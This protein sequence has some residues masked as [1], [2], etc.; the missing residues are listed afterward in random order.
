MRGCYVS[1][2]VVMGVFREEP[3]ARGQRGERADE[4]APTGAAALRELGSRRAEERPR[5]Q[6]ARLSRRDPRWCVGG[7]ANGPSRAT[8]SRV[9]AFI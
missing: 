5:N 2:K 6:L 1:G 3:P 8:R 4:L 7:A 9:I